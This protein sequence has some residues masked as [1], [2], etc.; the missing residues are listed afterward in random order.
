SPSSATANWPISASADRISRASHGRAPTA[1]GNQKRPLRRALCFP[2]ALVLAF[3]FWTRRGGTY[4]PPR[5]PR[6]LVAPEGLSGPDGAN[7]FAPWP[8]RAFKQS[9]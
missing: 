8:T 6:L 2:F 1:D 9:T 7:T 4:G 3:A 5:R